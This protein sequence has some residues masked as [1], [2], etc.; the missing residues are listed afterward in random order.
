[1]TP[2]STAEDFDF[3]AS[4]PEVSKKKGNRYLMD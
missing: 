1:M 4:V 2:E 3:L